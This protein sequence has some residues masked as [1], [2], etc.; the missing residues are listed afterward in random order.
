M[1]HI[2]ITIRKK[3]DH[4]TF[5][6][7][8]TYFQFLSP[9]FQI[10]LVVP[11]KN[12]Q[13]QDIVERN[14]AL[15]ICGGN[16][17]NPSYFFQSPHPQTILEDPDIEVMDFALLQQFYKARKKIFGICRGIQ[18]I[19][20]FFKGILYQDI[21]SQYSTSIQ[22][23]QQHHNIHIKEKTFLSRYF[24][25]TVHV[26]SFHHQNLKNVPHLLKIN[27]I[28]EDG[29]IEGIENHQIIAVQWH[30]ERMNIYHQN[31]F[32]TMMIDFIQVPH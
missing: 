27:A 15:L 28:S 9:Y 4:F 19:H 14:D 12:H 22:H 32:I 8:Q 23:H 3:D 13:Y 10:E 18:V 31:Q 25:S 5:F 1:Y 29:L 24:A 26:N 16:D 7:E 11:R 2:A 6:I 20:V 30:P 21:S 17:V